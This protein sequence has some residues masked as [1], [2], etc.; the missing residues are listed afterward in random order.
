M[1]IDYFVEGSFRICNKKC[2]NCFSGSQADETAIY[3]RGIFPDTRRYNVAPVPKESIDFFIMCANKKCKRVV[4]IKDHEIPHIAQN[5]ILTRKN[6]Y[7]QRAMAFNCRCHPNSQKKYTL[8]PEKNIKYDNSI[9][10]YLK[11]SRADCR[12]ECPGCNMKCYFRSIWLP[13]QVRDRITSRF[14]H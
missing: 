2:E 11:H 3:C 5:R 7:F 13:K 4:I 10:F 1:N 9:I 8:L 14:Y 6:S 12:I